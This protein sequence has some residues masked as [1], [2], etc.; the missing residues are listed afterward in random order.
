MLI[1]EIN[2]EVLISLNSL[3]NY[4]FIQFITLCFADTPIIFLPVFLV[5]MWIYYTYKKKDNIISDIHLIKNLL[6]K[7]KLLSIFYSVII[8]ISISLLIQQ[9]IH[10]QRPEEAIK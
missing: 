6:E 4:E 2:K 1:Q 8:A 3:T 10:I 5:G 7:E 9:F